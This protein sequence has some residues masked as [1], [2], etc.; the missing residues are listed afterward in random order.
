MKNANVYN[1][2]VRNLSVVF[3]QIRLNLH[4]INKLSLLLRKEGNINKK[5]THLCVGC[6][7]DVDGF[8]PPTLCL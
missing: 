3:N 7:V 1:C 5:P 4:F 2:F 8:E 6:D